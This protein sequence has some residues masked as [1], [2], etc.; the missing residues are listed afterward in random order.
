MERSTALDRLKKIIGPQFAYRIDP[1]AP[2]DAQRLAAKE[3]MPALNAERKAFGEAMQARMQQLLDNDEEYQHLK[4]KAEKARKAASDNAD[5]LL[6][7][8]ITVGRDLG[9]HMR[10]L[11]QAHSWEGI[12]EILKRNGGRV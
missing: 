9:T 3:A 10:V 1:D 8:K 2:T 5:I 12:F 6:T 7:H 11:A 4:A